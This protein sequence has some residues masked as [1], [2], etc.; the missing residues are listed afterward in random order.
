[1]GKWPS[2]QAH[3]LGDRGFESR[4]RNHFSLYNNYMITWDDEE[5]RPLRKRY[6]YKD[7][8]VSRF[9]EK[10]SRRD[11]FEMDGGRSSSHVVNYGV[12]VRQYNING[13]YEG[14][15]DYEEDRVGKP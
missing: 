8:R 11:T 3:N 6:L 13:H 5:A 10:F 4:L 7:Y 12:S 2:H 9:Y 1:M 14:C 15:V